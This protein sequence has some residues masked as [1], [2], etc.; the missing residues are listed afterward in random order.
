MAGLALFVSLGG[1]SYAAVSLSKGEV[2]SHHIADRAVRNAKLG[3]HAV[4]GNKIKAGAITASKIRNGSLRTRHFAPGVLPT[5]G[6]AA[7][8]A[9]A[10]G[11][12][13]ATGS[14]GDTGPKGDAGS[15]GP[16]G[17]AGP[18]GP[19]G[20]IGPAGAI[21]PDGP[22]GPIGPIGATG[23]VGSPG[24]FL[25]TATGSGAISTILGGLAGTGLVLPLQGTSSTTIPILG[26]TIPF[27]EPIAKAASIVP[28]DI[29]ITS[30]RLGARTSTPPPLV[31]STIHLQATLY[32]ASS[33]GGPLTPVPGAT[34]ITTPL[35]DPV[36]VGDTVEG[37][38]TGLSVP[39]AAGDTVVMVVSAEESG[40][41][42]GNSL[43]I[44]T[45]VSIGAS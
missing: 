12:T 10:A 19:P 4:T 18:T 33:Y 28:A 3:T 30:I 5:G 16:N 17:P 2:K 8:A 35:S 23:P 6:G 24:P 25:A 22:A 44:E 26:P 42:L 15:A 31:G 37:T 34:C 7:G 29:T 20:P 45:S 27:E 13:G 14:N 41:S 32:S 38:C 40:P 9:G 43:Q 11:D 36:T 1:T 39:L 21:G